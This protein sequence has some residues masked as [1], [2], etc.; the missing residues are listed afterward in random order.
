VFIP[1]CALKAVFH[2]SDRQHIRF[3][4]YAELAAMRVNEEKIRSV[5]NDGME[6]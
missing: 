6:V 1:F 5:P 2:E 3:R 4:V